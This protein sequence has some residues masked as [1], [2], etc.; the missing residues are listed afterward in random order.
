MIQC[1]KKERLVHTQTEPDKDESV[2]E[3]P[4]IKE[5]WS[6]IYKDEIINSQ[7][8]SEKVKK[9]AFITND[10]DIVG[11]ETDKKNVSNGPSMIIGSIRSSTDNKEKIS[12]EKVI[13]MRI[14]SIR[15]EKEETSECHICSLYIS[16]SK[17]QR[18]TSDL[19][20]NRVVFLMERSEVLPD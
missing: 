18:S 3:C 2:A 14:G 13:K 1:D 15:R 6:D 17:I 19:Y 7:V 9:W 12:K 16:S 10:R 20:M 8:E 4:N 5:I 11:L